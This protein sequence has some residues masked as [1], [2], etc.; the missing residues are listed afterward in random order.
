MNKIGIIDI[1]SNSMRLMLVEISNKKYF[2]MIDE[3]KVTVRLGMDMTPD[4]QLDNI[5]MEKALD[6][7]SDFKS[8]CE[9]LGECTIYPVATE[10][11]RRA[12]NQ[13][14]FLQMVSTKLNLEIRILSGKE[15]AYYDYFGVMNSM[16]CEN[17][18]IM[19]IGG[20]STELIFV[21]NS[22]IQASTSLP[23]GAI[24]LTEKFN[25]SKKMSDETEKK[26]KKFLL[27]QFEKIEWLKECHKLPLIGIGGTV[28]NVGKISR[29]STNYPLDRSHNY[30]MTSSEVADIYNSVK[31]KSLEQRKKVKGLSKERADI[32]IG[33]SS[34]MAVLMDYCKNPRLIVSGSGV[35]E[36]M[37]YEILN[38]QT[39]VVDVLDF[40]I[41]NTIESLDLDRAHAHYLGQLAE[42]LYT[43]LQ[44]LHGIN[45]KALP[46]LKTAAMLND[47]GKTINFY[48]HYKHSFY[49]MT[50]LPI[51]GLSHKELVM[52]A[53]TLAVGIKEN[54]DLESSPYK[55][56]LD[57]DDH[58]I[59]KKLGVI[60][61]LAEC[62]ARKHN[63][64]IKSMLCEIKQD[65]LIIHLKSES[66]TEVE[67]KEVA[68]SLA[69]FSRIFGKVLQVV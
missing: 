65:T 22:I 20:A 48:D 10:A 5:R 62:F 60:L 39:M 34:V 35:R 31:D 15:E 30:C 32:F 6:T 69:Y 36:G 21:K 68:N 63:E 57:E 16:N 45:S 51:Y 14:K 24:T 17:G 59:V 18:L 27:A 8:I 40:S 43:Q 23:L 52:A 33:A 54:F 64:N 41:N 26:V 3:I 42:S 58:T 67:R 44:P 7:L 38:G 47:C 28:R 19:D 66:T 50:N 61:R 13:Q 11:V 29:K 2:R 9:S 46:I 25:L 55:S 4:G 53:Y 12:A 1:G 49:M 37:I 56:L